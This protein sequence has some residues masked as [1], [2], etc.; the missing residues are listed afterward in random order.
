LSERALD[1]CVRQFNIPI[2]ESSNEKLDDSIVAAMMTRITLWTV[3]G[4]AFF[5]TV[6]TL[7][8]NGSKVCQTRPTELPRAAGTYRRVNNQLEF[9][10]LMESRV[11]LHV[12]WSHP[13]LFSIGESQRGQYF[14]RILMA[15]F[16]SSSSCFCVWWRAWYSSHVS[17]SCQLTSQA[18]QCL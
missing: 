14:V 4:T 7:S 3:V 6:K 9:F 18:V 1:C 12:M 8:S 16:E 10:E 5:V 11:D 17:S 2:E 15:F 13:S